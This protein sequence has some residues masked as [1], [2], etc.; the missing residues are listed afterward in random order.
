[1]DF[2]IIDFLGWF[3]WKFFLF[4]YIV[5]LEKNSKS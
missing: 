4:E 3:V 5:V 1:M 2:W